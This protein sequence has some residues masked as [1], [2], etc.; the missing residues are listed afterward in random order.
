MKKDMERLLREGLIG[1]KVSITGSRNNDAIGFAGV[2]VD[3]SRDMITIDCDGEKKRFIKDQQT[4][5][6]KINDLT[7]TVEGNMLAGRPEERIK[8]WLTRTSASK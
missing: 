2:V 6:F 1:A 8:K 3:E 4:F 5:A 7:I